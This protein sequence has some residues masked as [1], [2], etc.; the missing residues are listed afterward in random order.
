MP[1]SPASWRP[2][3]LSVIPHKIAE[4]E[5]A[6]HAG[7]DGQVGGGEVDGIRLAG[8]HIGVAV[9]GGRVPGGCRIL[10]G[11]GV[12]TGRCKMHIV[13]AG[14]QIVE[15]IV[16]SG[17]GGRGGQ[18]GGCIAS[19]QVTVTPGMPGS[20]ASWRPLSLVSFQTKSPSAR[21]D[22]AG[23]DGSSVSPR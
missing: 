20:P 16:T 21:L 14:D 12:S 19:K 3:A 8:G 18:H 6:D 23:I 13:G 17:V 5:V 10:R 7:I 22:H 9:I 2:L 4:R 1:G 15:D 11:E